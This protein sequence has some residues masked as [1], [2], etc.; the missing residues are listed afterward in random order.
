MS[1]LY[2]DPIVTYQLPNL[3]GVPLIGRYLHGQSV[4][5]PIEPT[6][7]FEAAVLD[8]LRSEGLDDTQI[9]PMFNDTVH[10]MWADNG[11]RTQYD[12]MANPADPSL[13]AATPA[14]LAVEFTRLLDTQPQFRP[15]LSNILQYKLDQG[16][17]LSAADEK[18]LSGVLSG[19]SVAATYSAYG[20]Y[21]RTDLVIYAPIAS[22]W[23]QVYGRDPTSAELQD[24]IHHGTS[25][26][27]YEDYV[28]S[29]PLGR[30]PGITVGQYLDTR[31]AADKISVALYGHPAND[32]IVT[33]LFNAGMMSTHAIQTWYDNL[34]AGIQAKGDAPMYNAAYAA[35]A[36]H[37]Q[38]IFNQA[39]DPRVVMG[40]V[41]HGLSQQAQTATPTDGT[42][43]PTQQQDTAQ[44][45]L[46]A[47]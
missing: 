28:R 24:V 32:G 33:E 15:I 22:L 47:P 31:N 11:I 21:N 46:P 30:I 9:A 34:E 13:A 37:T 5:E 2:P 35:L 1:S 4:S 27:E 12:H 23:K 8:M 42:V 38:G 18:R 41:Q 36:P 17:P 10:Q 16:I 7:D 39:P 14:Q 3:S 40:L 44:K 25:E 20:I 19:S 26:A 45:L 6:P 29:L 43:P